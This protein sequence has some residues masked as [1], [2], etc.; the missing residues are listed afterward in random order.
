VIHVF[1][2]KEKIS[3]MNGEAFL[4]SVSIT[5][6]I[7]ILLSLVGIWASLARSK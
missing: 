5:F 6:G 1:I 7:F 3:A 2:G 4:H